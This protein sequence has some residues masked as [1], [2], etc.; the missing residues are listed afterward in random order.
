MKIL[1]Q[2]THFITQVT[3]KPMLTRLDSSVVK[4]L[5]LHYQKRVRH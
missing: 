2:M 5:V 4:I 3:S 1:N